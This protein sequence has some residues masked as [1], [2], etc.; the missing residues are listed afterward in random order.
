MVFCNP[1]SPPACDIKPRHVISFMKKKKPKGELGLSP[2]SQCDRLVEL[3]QGGSQSQSPVFLSF[4]LFHFGFCVFFFA[5]T[6]FHKPLN[7]RQLLCS[8]R[9]ILVNLSLAS[10]FKWPPLK[11]N[12][13]FSSNTKT[14]DLVSSFS[15]EPGN[16]F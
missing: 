16:Q 12:F 8:A 10:G 4:Y 1:L 13:T 5:D 11:H 3:F 2:A 6:V 14:H 7:I 15:D 9:M